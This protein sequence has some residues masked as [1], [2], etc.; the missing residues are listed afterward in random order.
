MDVVISNCVFTLSTEKPRALAEAA[1]VLRPDGRFGISDVLAEPGLDPA[2]RAEA[3]HAVG[4]PVGTLTAAQYRDQL[5]AAGFV[6]TAIIP[7]RPLTG[8]STPRSCKPPHHDPTTQLGQPDPH[9]A[10]PKLRLP[11]MTLALLRGR[12]C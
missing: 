12:G 7:T 6:N 9:G 11:P 4:C 2:R 8:G 1:R 5:L 3:E 10:R